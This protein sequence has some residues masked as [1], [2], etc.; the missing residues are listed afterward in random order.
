[1]LKAAQGK[2][3]EGNCI[4]AG[5]CSPQAFVYTPGMYSSSNQDF[6]RGTVSSFY[7]MF[8]QVVSRRSDAGDDSEEEFRAFAFTN[9]TR[10]DEMVCPLDNM[11]WELKVRNQAMKRG[12]ASVYMDSMKQGLLMFRVVVDVVV[13][14]LYIVMQIFICLFRLLVSIAGGMSE[15]AAELEFWFNELV[16]LIVDAIKRLADMLFNMLFSLGA[17]GSAMKSVLQGICWFIDKLIWAWNNSRMFCAQLVCT[18]CLGLFS[19]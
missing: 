3:F 14:A 1:M 13:K 19:C 16:I 15:V 11:E 17:L 2:V 8:K 10:D 9:E 7:E 18:I 4:F 6:V 12:C 5:V